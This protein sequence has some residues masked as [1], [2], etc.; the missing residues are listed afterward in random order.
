MPEADF[1]QESSAST[2]RGRGRPRKYPLPEGYVPPPKRVARPRR[3][4]LAEEYND[5]ED[6]IQEIVERTTPSGRPMRRSRK[7]VDYAKI[8]QGEAITNAILAD[9]EDIELDEHEEEENQL[10]LDKP[11]RGRPPKDPSKGPV[12]RPTPKRKAIDIDD[13]SDDFEPD[14][15]GEDDDEF[16]AA[17]EEEEEDD[18][19]DK[20]EED[21]ISAS[22][23]RP[24]RGVTK[25]GTKARS[26][27]SRQASLKQAQSVEGRMLQI[28][29][30]RREA[31]VAGAKYRNKWVN[32]LA[33]LYNSKIEESGMPCLNVDEVF[34]V[35]LQIVREIENTRQRGRKLRFDIGYNDS[36]REIN[37]AAC[38]ARD[39]QSLT[40]GNRQG[41]IINVAGY[42]AAC[43]WAPLDDS[44]TM[45]M[46]RYVIRFF[47][48]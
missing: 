35:D 9:K 33:V 44:G 46:L 26:R 27:T 1:T 29:G 15:D 42:P 34:D 48:D 32:D 14:G 30:H 7:D 47:S 23:S 8:E 21:E 19:E 20:E 31:L 11:K 39:V 3:E 45:R 6:Q 16:E 36:L 13:D 5:D 2:K 10:S 22:E 18:A 40:S 25:K 41:C 12:A 4:V 38:E 24:K 43:E 17:A 28:F 37:L